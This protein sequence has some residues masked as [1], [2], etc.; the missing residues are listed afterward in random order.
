[1]ATAYCAMT[2]VGCL[3]RDAVSESCKTTSSEPQLHSQL[4]VF[5]RRAPVPSASLVGKAD[6][7]A[8]L[9]GPGSLFRPGHDCTTRSY[10]TAFESIDY[11]HR[12]A[13]QSCAGA[14]QQIRPHA[15]VLTVV[16]STVSMRISRCCVLVRAVSE[17]QPECRCKRFQDTV[18]LS[19]CPSET[20]HGALG[21]SKSHRGRLPQC[22]IS[23]PASLHVA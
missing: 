16:V 7:K 2:M 4:P 14:L 17:S 22:C 1:M 21:S 19:I 18:E 11:T 8:D 6:S 13:L 23:A 10:W 9:R 20:E 15:L 3:T 12:P 5:D